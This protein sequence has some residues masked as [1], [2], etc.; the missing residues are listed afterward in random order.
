MKLQLFNANIFYLIII[1]NKP[2]Q[3]IME[4]LIIPWDIL[5]NLCEQHLIF[6]DT[7]FNIFLNIFW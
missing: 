1:R 5:N 7:E 2:K 4:N 6:I 3:N